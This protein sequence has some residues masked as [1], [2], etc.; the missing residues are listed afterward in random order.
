MGTNF[1]YKI[2]I[3]KRKQEEL[4]SMITENPDFSE[5]KN[6][7]WDIEQSNNI[8]LGKR[9]YGWQFL[10][11]FHNGKFF[12]PDLDSI[13]HFLTSGN[14]SIE[15]EYGEKFS[16]EQF[17][18]EIEDCL[19]K[20]DNHVDIATYYRKYPTERYGITSSEQEFSSDGLR[21][22]KYEDFS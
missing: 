5:L 19:Y 6:E 10:W 4:K 22:S 1:Y 16:L 11:D 2:P 18:D 21:F 3:D 7:I 9:S 14:G 13:K 15:N 8:H 12:E 17:I 20:D